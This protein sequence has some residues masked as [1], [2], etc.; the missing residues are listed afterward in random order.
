MLRA[1]TTFSPRQQLIAPASPCRRARPTV[2][3]TPVLRPTLRARPDRLLLAR[4]PASTCPF[5]TSR[6]TSSDRSA[7]PSGPRLGLLERHDRLVNVVARKAKSAVHALVQRSN[8]GLLSGADWRRRLA[9]LPERLADPDLRDPLCADGWQPSVKRVQ[10][11]LAVHEHRADALAAAGAEVLARRA[12]R[13]HAVVVLDVPLAL[14]VPRHLQKLHVA[15]RL[16]GERL[17]LGEDVRARGHALGEVAGERRAAAGRFRSGYRVRLGALQ[18][19]SRNLHEVRALDVC[20]KVIAHK[21]RRPLVHAPE[22]RITQVQRHVPPVPAILRQL[23][24][25]PVL[26]RR[27]IAIPTDILRREPAHVAA[28]DEPKPL[29]ASLAR[30]MCPSYEAAA[31][32]GNGGAHS[33]GT[34]S[35]P[36]PCG[37]SHQK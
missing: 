25:I 37:T 23:A 16:V 4:K 32:F 2:Q 21:D 20:E 8:Q 22:P 14:G 1:K 29:R 10:V 18:H 35:P 5:P 17:H 27:N 13:V 9:V 11:E 28:D 26:L 34:G 31:G 24:S 33:A 15:Q 19:R 6:T 7:P 3:H 12:A 36:R 30:R